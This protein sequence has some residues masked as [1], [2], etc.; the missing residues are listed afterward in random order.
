MDELEKLKRAHHYM[1]LLA[2]GIDPLTESELPEDSAL[3]NVRLARCFFYVADIL[4]QVIENGGVVGRNTAPT[5][6]NKLPFALTPEQKER[7]EISD[8]LLFISKFTDKIN[9]LIDQVSM[10]KLKAAAFGAWLL[11]KGFLQ[12]EIHNGSR[13]RVPSQAGRQLGISSEFRQTERGTYTALFYNRDAQQFLFDHL[14]EIIAVS[15]G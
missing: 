13:S 2:N 15:N 9:A 3:N 7:I 8:E 6:E 11:E 10:K 4:Q 12:E 1:A 14:D 5:K